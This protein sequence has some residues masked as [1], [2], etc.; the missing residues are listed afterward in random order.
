[1]SRKSRHCRDESDL[2]LGFYSETIAATSSVRSTSNTVYNRSAGVFDGSKNDHEDD[3]DSAEHGGEFYPSALSSP[4][5]RG[6]DMESSSSPLKRSVRISLPS[7]EEHQDN[8]YSEH[9]TSFL[10]EDGFENDTSYSSFSPERIKARKKK[11][12]KKKAGYRVHR[13]SYTA[14][15]HV[16]VLFRMYGSAFPQVLPFCLA[17]ILWTFIVVT[18]RTYQ[19]CDLTF[20]SSV[21]H[22]FMGLLVSF[23]IVSRSKISYDRFMEFRR[24]LAVTYRVCR[25]LG[26]FTAVYTSSTQTPAAQAWRQEVCYRT[27]LL[28]RVTMDALL[29]S[30]TEREHWEEEYIDASD[31]EEDSDE[32]DN[33]RKYSKRKTLSQHLS[34][35]RR[36]SHGRRSKI[37]EN[38]RAPI[39]FQHVLRQTIMDHPRSLGYKMPVNEYRDLLNFVTIFND[40]FHN[41]RVLIFTPY[42]FALVQMTRAFLFFWVY[43]LPMVLLKDYR[44]WSSVLIVLLVSFGFIGIE[45]V[46]IALD[47]PFGDDT[48]D[49]DEHGM[50]LLVYEDIYLSLYR[51]DGPSAAFALRERVLARYR[52][53]RGL[54]CYRH[55]LQGFDLW[56]RHLPQPEQHEV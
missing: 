33:E 13:V 55:D 48:N 36:L 47:D 9:E 53:G 32:E 43:T 20:H 4:K 42:P 45:Y 16:Q 35:M 51:T 52:Q 3:D 5:K 54:D 18:L 39:T 24:H 6:G 15:N 56:E 12:R 1:M 23:L 10:T 27:I 38:F 46:S 37:D 26:Q 30:S 44:V 14:H 21:G 50:A 31:E 41:F 34:L 25:D 17:N 8:R 28:L 22:S 19:V 11:R 40:A 2:L 29:W 49:V 7:G